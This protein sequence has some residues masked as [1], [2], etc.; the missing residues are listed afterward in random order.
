MIK[1]SA[2]TAIPLVIKTYLS[3]AIANIIDNAAI[4]VND[5]IINEK[6]CVN[7]PKPTAIPALQPTINNS[8]D[9]IPYRCDSYL[10]KKLP[11]FEIVFDITFC[12][13]CFHKCMPNQSGEL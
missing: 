3:G 6:T 10:L 2:T 5:K 12:F 7:A 9:M 1:I 8:I 11:L 4:V 13:N